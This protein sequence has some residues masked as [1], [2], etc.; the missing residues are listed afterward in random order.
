MQFGEEDNTLG[1]PV[2][3]RLLVHL[4]ITNLVSRPLLSFLLLMLPFLKEVN[5]L[6]HLLK[7]NLVGVVQSRYDCIDVYAFVCAPL[8]SP[9]QSVVRCG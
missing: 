5:M 3:F 4:E 9:A 8:P 6:P 7:R 2:A 1:S